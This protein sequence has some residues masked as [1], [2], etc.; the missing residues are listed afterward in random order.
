[1]PQ[2]ATTF[3][4]PVTI[5]LEIV[6]ATLTAAPCRLNP[7]AWTPTGPGWR[8]LADAAVTV[9]Q[10]RCSLYG[11]ACGDALALEMDYPG[12]HLGVWNGV[13]LGRGHSNEDNG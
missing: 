5:A 11:N 6:P 9:C 4:Q 1:M 2:T 13:S 8:K 3:K 12:E 10:T 7:E